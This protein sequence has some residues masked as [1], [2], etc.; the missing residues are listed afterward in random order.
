MPLPAK[1]I[2]EWL[3]SVGSVIEGSIE[4]ETV[5]RNVVTNKGL[6]AETQ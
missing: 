6:M 1:A 2:P 4:V 5:V 3:S